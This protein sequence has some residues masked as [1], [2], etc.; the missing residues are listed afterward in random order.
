MIIST[1]SLIEA[2]DALPSD[3]CPETADLFTKFLLLS[4]ILLQDLNGLF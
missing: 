1:T 4:V 2:L 3:R